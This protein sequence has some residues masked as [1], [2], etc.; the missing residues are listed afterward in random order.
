MSD[1]YWEYIKLMV[2]EAKLRSNG[3]E[4]SSRMDGL[5]DEMDDYWYKMT[6]EEHDKIRD[7]GNFSS[8][9]GV[10][11]ADQHNKTAPAKVG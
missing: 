8:L 2:S 11:D 4:E 9:L 7:L 3:L 6:A 10:D 5:H 1:A